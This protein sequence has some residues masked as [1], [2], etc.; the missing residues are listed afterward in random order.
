MRQHAGA[1]PPAPVGSAAQH[2][3]QP[4]ELTFDRLETIIIGRTIADALGHHTHAR[5]DDGQGDQA[6]KRK[7]QFRQKHGFQDSF[8]EGMD[9]GRD[10]T[11]QGRTGRDQRRDMNRGID[12]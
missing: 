8:S 12:E 4:I 7:L 1:A 3:Q 9:R 5:G 6:Q 11:G 2:F 10:D